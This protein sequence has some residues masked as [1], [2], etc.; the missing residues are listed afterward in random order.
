MKTL[1]LC[2][3]RGTRL[4]EHTETLP[5]V[6]VEIGGRPI[7][8]HI[9]QIYASQSLADFVLATGYLGGKVSEYFLSREAS[10][11]QPGV[12]MQF[13]DT[14]QE[15]N[16]GGRV[17]KCKS[18]LD[19]ETFCVTYGDCVADIDLG[20]LLAFHAAHGRIATITVIQPRLPFGVVSLGAGDSVARFEEKPRLDGWING[21][22]FVFNS[23]IFNY[24]TGDEMLENGPFERL[25][26]DG[27]LMAYRHEGFWACMDTYKE[28]LELNHLWASGQAPWRVGF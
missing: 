19:Q 17:A 27:Q 13:I 20:R 8:W 28:N 5:K 25:S 11:K 3:G 10:D 14:G 7:L 9:M 21:G 15:T 18:H 6:L 23:E 2:G 22:F 12:A 24:L 26:A 4:R 16:T 1:I